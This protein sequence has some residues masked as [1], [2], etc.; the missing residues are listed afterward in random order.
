MEKGRAR[1]PVLGIWGCVKG[2]AHEPDGG[3]SHWVGERFQYQLGGLC[4]SS[5][6]F[7]SMVIHQRQDIFRRSDTI[8]VTKSKGSELARDKICN[9]VVDERERERE[10]VSDS[11]IEYSV[12]R[13]WRTSVKPVTTGQ[14]PGFDFWSSLPQAFHTR[15]SNHC[16]G[17]PLVCYSTQRILCI[18]CL[19]SRSNEMTRREFSGC[20]P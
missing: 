15:Q 16:L 12:L 9:P 19:R 8:T 11:S 13:K 20:L 3:R 6:S 7:W 5:Y 2:G 14:R 1:G 17:K 10:V 18:G 4:A